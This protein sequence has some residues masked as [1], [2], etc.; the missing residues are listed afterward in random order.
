MK[1]QA[2]RETSSLTSTEITVGNGPCCV[3]LDCVFSRIFIYLIGEIKARVLQGLPLSGHM[4]RNTISTVISLM[5]SVRG[6]I[7][8]YDDSVSGQ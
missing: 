2:D 3:L 6:S 5:D 1:L 7:S 4:D 8:L